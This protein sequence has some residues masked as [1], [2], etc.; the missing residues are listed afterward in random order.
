MDA[1]A[2]ELKKISA[3]QDVLVFQEAFQA[4]TEQRQAIVNNRSSLQLLTA[5]LQG[6]RKRLADRPVPELV[7]GQSW[8]GQQAT[9]TDL[10]AK[11]SMVRSKQQSEMALKQSLLR[12][13]VEKKAF[14]D[15]VSAWLDEHAADELLL[16]DFPET[17]KLKKMR[18]EWVVLTAKHKG[19]SK[20][21]QK[22]SQVINDNQSALVQAEK[23]RRELGRSLAYEQQEL[24]GLRHDNTVEQLAELYSEQRERT[25]NFQQLLDLA[26]AYGELAKPGFNW[27]GAADKPPQLVDPNQLA[28]ELERLT[29]EVKR[30]ENILAILV[31]TKSFEIQ[32]KRLADNRK[33]LVDGKPCPLCGALHHPFDNNPPA[34]ADPLKAVADQQLKIRTLKMFVER[35]RKQ[36]DLSQKTSVKNQAKSLRRQQ[37]QSDWLS[38]CNRLNSAAGLQIKDFPAMELLLS[39][40][41]RQLSE[42]TALLRACLEKQARIAKWQSQLEENAQGLEQ[43]KAR[44]EHLAEEASGQLQAYQ[45]TG[46]Q[47]ASLQQEEQGLTA[48]ITAQLAALGE[49]M[50][51]KGK[52]DALFDKLNERRQVYYGYA[53]RK[54]SLADEI[55]NLHQKSAE[56][57]QEIERNQELIELHGEQLQS[58]ELIGLH[59][60]IT[61]KER[62]RHEKEHRLQEQ[63]QQLHDLQ[64][65]LQAKLEASPYP[66]IA[67]VEGLLSLHAMQAKLEAEQNQLQQALANKQAGRDKI[68]ALLAQ[69]RQL[70]PGL[71]PLDEINLQLRVI[72]EKMDIA[73]L[74]SQRLQTLL[75]QQTVLQGRQAEIMNQLQQ[76]QA[77]ADACAAEAELLNADQGMALRRKAQSR[78]ADKL[79]AQ[80]NLLLEKLSGR[81]Y[82]RQKPDGQGLALEIE[83]TLQGNIRRLPKTL[84][85]GET[86]VVSLALALGLSELANNGKAV[87]SLFLDEGF[88]NLDAESLFTVLSTLENLKT[89]GK[90]VGVISHV[91]S[92]QKH[93]K[94]Q[95]Q[96]VKK[97]NGMGELRR[98]S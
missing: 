88:G 45:E 63:Q 55:E 40:E 78:L 52:E 32:V 89:H 12:Q 16:T 31:Q 18:A 97:P 54:K 46:A 29:E 41:K 72:K 67:E 15:K 26:V 95:L 87:D 91:E 2:S 65:A 8:S 77:I 17:G 96:V 56:C 82:L 9:I 94:A 74:E 36:I 10:G 71:P 30:E 4:I 34:F 47:L 69:Q 28:L 1:L 50:P 44:A 61:E 27:F 62:L 57:D 19:L 75:A 53:Y 5:E 3:T 20:Q 11:L 39:T 25:H 58:A 43:M 42:I 66:S 14:L 70:Q 13:M 37:L 98:L 60:V 51:D 86:F 21:H 93:I 83:D 48:K 76:Q 81:Y 23:R 49:K 79:L 24:L 35:V 80:T 7:S 68:A 38:L 6:L 59:L 92:V 73:R 84:S 90:T 85:G 33:Y 64:L 22:I